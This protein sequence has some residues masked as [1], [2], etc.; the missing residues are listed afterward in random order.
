VLETFFEIPGF[1]G[2]ARGFHSDHM[3]RS[4]QTA[5]RCQKP[6]DPPV[7]CEPCGRRRGRYNVKK[8]IAEHEDAK[9]TDL[10]S[11]TAPR[12]D[13][14][15]RI[16]EIAQSLDLIRRSPEPTRRRA[17]HDRRKATLAQ[18]RIYLIS[19]TPSWIAVVSL[20][21]PNF[22]TFIGMSNPRIL[23]KSLHTRQ[24]TLSTYRNIAGDDSTMFQFYREAGFVLTRASEGVAQAHIVRMCHSHCCS[25]S[26]DSAP[27]FPKPTRTLRQEL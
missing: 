10:R 14:T 21:C 12:R 24:P 3:S 7:A 19:R 17:A 8:L 11:P 16:E 26:F 15:V 1:R 25:L 2:A 5:G 18:R 13:A 4:P 22:G 23:H 9:L 6:A 27:D 20:Y